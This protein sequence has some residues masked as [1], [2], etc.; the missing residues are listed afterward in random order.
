VRIGVDLHDRTNRI[1]TVS[2]KGRT[3]MK[4]ATQLNTQQS[5]EQSVDNVHANATLIMHCCNV[6]AKCN[7]AH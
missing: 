3:Q 1:H 2:Y 7:V 4:A 5:K 6:M